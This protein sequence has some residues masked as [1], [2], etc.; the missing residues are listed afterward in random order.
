MEWCCA[1]QFRPYYVL[2]LISYYDRTLNMSGFY[3]E[4]HHG[5]GP[6]DGAGGAVKNVVFRD[7]TS[8]KCTINLP[9]EFT[10]YADKRGESITTLYFPEWKLFEGP[11]EVAKAPKIPQTLQVHKVMR[12]MSINGISYLEFFY[13]VSDKKPFF[14]QYYRKECDPEICG[15]EGMYVEDGGHC[16]KCREVE[17]GLD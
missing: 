3:N 12:H 13:L 15:H 10:E 11:N 6:I 4:R 16:A 8:E 5:K 17:N 7:A 9:K 1:T 2:S 14:T